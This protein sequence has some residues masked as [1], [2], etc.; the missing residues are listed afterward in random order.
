MRQKYLLAFIVG[1]CI[2]LAGCATDARESAR[3]VEGMQRVHTLMELI[4]PPEPGN[5]WGNQYR[6]TSDADLYGYLLEYGSFAQ[7]QDECEG[8]GRSEL[9]ARR[10]SDQH[11]EQIVRE[12]LVT[13]TGES[14]VGDK[15]VPSPSPTCA[16]ATRPVDYR[17]RYERVLRELESRLGVVP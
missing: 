7:V 9:E 13:K 14:A 10:S 5:P 8:L 15:A 16:T 11:R 17:E 12:R 2:I 1:F 4:P 3:Q 6:R